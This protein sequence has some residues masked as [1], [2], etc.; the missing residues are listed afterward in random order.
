METIVI[1]DNNKLEKKLI[2]NFEYQD[3]IEA[4]KSCDYFKKHSLVSKYQYATE[5]VTI[6]NIAKYSI[7][8]LKKCNLFTS[9]ENYNIKIIN[10]FI[11][12]IYIAALIWNLIDTNKITYNGNKV[13]F[14]KNYNT[15]D[16]DLGSIVLTYGGKNNAAVEFYSQVKN[17]KDEITSLVFCIYTESYLVDKENYLKKIKFE[18]SN[19]LAIAGTARAGMTLDISEINVHNI[20]QLIEGTVN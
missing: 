1:M 6:D 10:S 3:L 13:E 9:D 12:S 5:K 7:E 2:T 19:T 11:F 15:K 14:A 18:I 20:I 4:L 8:L 17:N 16:Y